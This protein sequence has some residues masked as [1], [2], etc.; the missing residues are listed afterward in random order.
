MR[1]VAER[2]AMAAAAKRQR[3]PMLTRGDE[4]MAE[5]APWL[6]PSPIA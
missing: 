5:A 4:L 2:A 1:A 6:G 3:A